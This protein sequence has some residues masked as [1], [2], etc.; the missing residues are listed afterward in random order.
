MVVVQLVEQHR[1]SEQTQNWVK[2]TLSLIYWVFQMLTLLMLLTWTWKL[3]ITVR[4]LLMVNLSISPDYLSIVE[5]PRG[6][7]WKCRQPGSGLSNPAAADLAWR[8]PHFCSASMHLPISRHTFQYMRGS[9]LC[10]EVLFD[11]NYL[12]YSHYYSHVSWRER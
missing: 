6:Y 3:I 8:I 10:F 12:E 4:S 11:N 5:P 1:A 7:G 2:T 9:E